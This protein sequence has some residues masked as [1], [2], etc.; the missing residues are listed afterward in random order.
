MKIRA[1][2]RRI[3]VFAGAKVSEKKLSRKKKLEIF[4]SV[5]NWRLASSG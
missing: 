3:T 5:S 1:H 4:F 2:G